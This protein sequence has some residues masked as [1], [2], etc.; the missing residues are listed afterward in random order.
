MELKKGDVPHE[1]RKYKKSFL[2]RRRN[3]NIV[4]K[5]SLDYYLRHLKKRKKNQ[6]I[7]VK[8]CDTL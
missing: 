4:T 5:I 8:V 2:V 6:L 7:Q 1:C 3:F